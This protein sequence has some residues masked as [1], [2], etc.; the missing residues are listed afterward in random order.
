MQR[1]KLV[2]KNRS[3]LPRLISRPATYNVCAKERRII[4]IIDRDASAAALT[5]AA[6]INF[7]GAIGRNQSIDLQNPLHQ[8]LNRTSAAPP[9][10]NGLQLFP[11]PPPLPKLVGVMNDPLAVPP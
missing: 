11:L 1:C 9:K 6:R 3:R 7:V 2:Q 5:T 10:P 8:Q 4:S